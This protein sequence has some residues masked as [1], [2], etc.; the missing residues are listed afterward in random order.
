M[1][2]RQPSVQRH[3]AGLGAGAQ[4]HEDHNH[5]GQR[6]GR[7]RGSDRIEIVTGAAREQAEGEQQRQRAETRHQKIDIAGA[8]ILD[9][10]VMRHDH[11]PGGQRHEFP[12]DQEAEG[13]VCQ[14]DDIHRCEIGG[15]ERQHA[16]GGVLV[17]A[18]T[19]R[20]QARSDAAEINDDE[21]EGGQCI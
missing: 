21:E 5:A 3:Q 7:M 14:H 17:L 16:S 11:R 15:I 19:E 9:L 13:I 18:V 4:Q 8:D 12:G 10:P 6:S 1:G 2:E 20:E